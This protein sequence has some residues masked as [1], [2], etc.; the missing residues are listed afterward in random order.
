MTRNIK[1]G[2]PVRVVDEHGI[3]HAGLVTQQWGTGSYEDSNQVRVLLAINV[4]F[5]SADENKND[6]YGR[7][8]EHL[9]SLQHKS[10]AGQ[11]PGRYWFQ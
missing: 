6:T 4:V 9:S 5:V 2:D 1:I 7:Q 11:C 3:E 8:T 10:V